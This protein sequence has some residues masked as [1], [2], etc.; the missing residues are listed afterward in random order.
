MDEIQLLQESISRTSGMRINLVINENRSHL[1]TILDR[2]YATA[3]LSVHRMFLSAP[4]HVIAAMGSYVKAYDRE[5]L[6]VVSKYIE[7]NVGRA[8]FSQ[9]FDAEKLQ[10]CGDY[11]DLKKTMEEVR[12]LYFPDSQPLL[13]TWFRQK[14]SRSRIIFGQ[15]HPLMRLVK[16]NKKLDSLSVPEYFLKYVIFHEMLHHHIPTQTSEKGRRLIHSREFRGRERQFAE[17]LLAT[18]WQNKNRHLFF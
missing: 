12:A 3:R 4:E 5:A 7:A 8:E 13:I 16:I 1:F 9:R 2:R 11:Y 6:K 14:S 18:E 10:I 15:Y 17:Y